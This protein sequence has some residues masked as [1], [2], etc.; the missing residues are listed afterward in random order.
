M[1]EFRH[2]D[3]KSTIHVAYALAEGLLHPGAEP[4]D[5]SK[6]GNKFLHACYYT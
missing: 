5:V 4:K 6:S 1:S 2:L 3:A